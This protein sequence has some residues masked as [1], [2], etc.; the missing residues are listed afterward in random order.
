MHR[1]QQLKQSCT[2]ETVSLTAL[3]RD[4]PR[5]SQLYITHGNGREARPKPALE[6][7]RSLSLHDEGSDLLGMDG[8]P[9]AAILMISFAFLKT[10][11]ERKA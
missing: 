3:R 9:P 8:Q 2:K 6:E 4:L 11:G 5:Y 1:R 7:W 10:V